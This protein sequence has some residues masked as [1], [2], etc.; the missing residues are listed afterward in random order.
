MVSQFQLKVA[1]I[2]GVSQS[3]VHFDSARS[4]EFLDLAVEMLH[5]ILAA[6]AHRVQQSLSIP[7]ALFHIVA[8]AQSRLQYLHRCHPARTILAGNKPLRNDVS[9]TLRQTIGH[10]VLLSRGKDSHHSL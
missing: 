3:S 8:S 7:F 1:G 5:P 4:Y 2:G 10:S 6:N 9:K